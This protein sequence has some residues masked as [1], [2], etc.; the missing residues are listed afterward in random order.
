MAPTKTILVSSTKT[1]TKKRKSD[2]GP[3]PGPSKVSRQTLDSFFAPRISVSSGNKKE[4]NL[5]TLNEEQR[6]VLRMVVEEGK[7]VFFTGSAGAF[8][9]CHRRL[10]AD[11][12]HIEG[13]GKSLLLRAIITALRKKHAGHPDAVSVTASTGM[14][15]SN[16]GGNGTFPNE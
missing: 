7:N 3:K 12:I 10:N 1:N 9:L 6:R 8:D 16:I 4:V 2:A 13:T 14:A 5:V 15:A 11:C